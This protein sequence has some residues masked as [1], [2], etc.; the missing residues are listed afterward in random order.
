[1]AKGAVGTWI[2]EGA[3]VNMKLATQI[4][5]GAAIGAVAAALFLTLVIAL[6]DVLS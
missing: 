3:A 2:E 5:L 6:S 4:V 1:M